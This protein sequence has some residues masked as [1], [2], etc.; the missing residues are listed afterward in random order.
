MVL[1]RD[2]V[3]MVLYGGFSIYGSK[4]GIQKTWFYRGFSKYGS[5]GDSVNILYR[6]I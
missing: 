5:I 3:N 4:R 1:Y 6:G 2:S